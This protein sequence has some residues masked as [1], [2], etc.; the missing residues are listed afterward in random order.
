MNITSRASRGIGLIGL[1]GRMNVEGR[2]RNTLAL[3]SPMTP[4]ARCT[5][6]ED[7]VSPVRR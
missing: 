6:L 2:R 7:D 1:I 5:L 4:I 3:M